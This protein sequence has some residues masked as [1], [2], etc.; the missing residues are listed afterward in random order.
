MAANVDAALIR[1]LP[2]LRAERPEAVRQRLVSRQRRTLLEGDGRLF[3]I[4]ADHPA[5]GSLG[6][7]H[8][9]MAM[10]DR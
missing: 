10:A 9:P 4:A 6:V 2:E 8:D 7:G 3:I 1:R 5:R